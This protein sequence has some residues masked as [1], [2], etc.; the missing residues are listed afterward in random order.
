MPVDQRFYLA[1][2]TLTLGSIIDR[3]GLDPS[4]AAHNHAEREI[5]GIASFE[6]AGP[7]D[8]CFYEG[9]DLPATGRAP[10]AQGACFVTEKLAARLK[11]VPQLIGVSDPRQ[12][13][14]ELS[15]T[16]FKPRQSF[17]ETG[18]ATV[19]ESALI[20]AR[21]VLG[22]GV[23][24]G[25]GTQIG[26]NCVIGPGVQIG[27][28]CHIG[29]NA[30]ISFALIGNHVCLLAGAR[31]GE[32]GFGVAGTATGLRDVPHFG[33]VI[34]QDNVTIGAN[35]CVDRGQLDDTL[36]GEGTKIDNLCHIG[37]NT[38]IGRNVVMAAFAGISGSVK[39]G[40]NVRMGGRVGLID[41]LTV[42]DNAQI[43]AGAAVLNN[44]P[45]G[46]TW[47]GMPAKPIKAWQRELVWL[48]RR[49]GREG[50]K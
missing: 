11:N 48:K 13:F 32:A 18:M 15:S 37:H 36:I 49:A 14:L 33:R 19:H 34:I 24:I 3:L 41:H 23:A 28:N 8:L 38:Q 46:E 35:S 20:G 26:A 39:I 12:S 16:V 43:A 6:A 17:K 44:V 47:A 25:E 4:H 45:A 22:A 42:G 30:T 50:D 27:Q 7:H 9:D 31:I 1:R 5:M 10:W 29:A 2:E 21:C 40:D